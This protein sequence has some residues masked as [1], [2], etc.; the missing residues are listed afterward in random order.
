MEQLF[1]QLDYMQKR[2]SLW[3][4]SREEIKDGG[5]QQQTRKLGC[6]AIFAC[7]SNYVWLHLSICKSKTKQSINVHCRLNHFNFLTPF[8]IV[9]IR[10]SA[11]LLCN[12]VFFFFLILKYFITA[13][14]F[15]PAVFFILSWSIFCS[16][17]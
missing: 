8:F 6:S 14:R 13:H 7:A 1:F 12:I 17:N 15:M 4:P 9:N 11:F 10:L 16:I 3:L 2:R 5:H